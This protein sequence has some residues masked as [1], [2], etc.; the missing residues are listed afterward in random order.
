MTAHTFPPSYEAGEFV[1]EGLFESVHP[2]NVEIK[3]NTRTAAALHEKERKATGGRMHDV[4]ARV[5][6]RRRKARRR[7]EKKWDARGDTS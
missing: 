4:V 2:Q 7:T 5:S 6:H 1:G 3:G